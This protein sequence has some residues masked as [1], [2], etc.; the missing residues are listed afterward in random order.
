MP[1]RIFSESRWA[2]EDELPKHRVVAFRLPTHRRARNVRTLR[3]CVVCGKYSSPR[4]HDD[5]VC[6]QKNGLTG[7]D[8]YVLTHARGEG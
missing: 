1:R 4:T 3:E 5:L 2:H 8:V 7:N 6:A